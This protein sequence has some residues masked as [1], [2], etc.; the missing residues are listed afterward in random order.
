MPFYAA[1]SAGI[2]AKNALEFECVNIASGP[3]VAAALVSGAAQFT[4]NT[5][6]NII[7]LL[8]KSDIVAF[9]AL[10]EGQ[11]FDIIVRA[12]FPLPSASQG[13]QGVM[14]DLQNAKIGVVARNAAAE[15]IARLLFLEASLDPEKAT[16]IATGLPAPTLAAMSAKQIDAAITLEPGLTQATLD[17]IAV[18]PFSIAGGTGPK[19]LNWPSLLAATSREYYQKN[20][21]VVCRYAKSLREGA[22]YIRDPKNRADVIKMMDTSLAIKDVKLAE[23]LLDTNAKY[24]STSGK[25]DNALID[26]VGQQVL[27]LKKAEKAYKAADFVVTPTC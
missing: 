16:Y 1:Q 18:R 15:D 23:A 24:L 22:E 6:N 26:T 2:F 21:S 27:T 4:S 8:P 13:W 5:P 9:S 14:K 10:Q 7:P 20:Q 25:I 19:S 12:D 3:E 17:K 11:Y